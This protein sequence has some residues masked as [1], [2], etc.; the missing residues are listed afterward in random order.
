MISKI[1]EK[2][3]NMDGKLNKIEEK[4]ARKWRR[5]WIEPN[6]SIGNENFKKTDRQTNQN[7][8]HDQ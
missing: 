5:I 4:L 7:G 6:R 1:D 3:N 2:I 8:K